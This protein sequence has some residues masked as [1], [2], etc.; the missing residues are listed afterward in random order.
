MY[1]EEQE[2]GQT[3]WE[4]TLVSYRCETLG[5]LSDSPGVS[6]L[7]YGKKRME[8]VTPRA[9]GAGVRPRN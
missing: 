7:A 3:H 1:R 9:V 4:P 5:Q 2:L 8:I 6:V